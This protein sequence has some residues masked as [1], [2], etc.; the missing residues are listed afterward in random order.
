MAS[1][2]FK[3]SLGIVRFP[4]GSTPSLLRHRSVMD[5][6]FKDETMANS[7]RVPKKDGFESPD[8]LSR[9]MRPLTEQRNDQRAGAAAA[10]TGVGTGAVAASG[11]NSLKP[12]KPYSPTAAPVWAS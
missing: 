12:P 8:I 10:L 11:G 5:E 4:E 9:M 3:T 7:R 6:T 2:V 1:L